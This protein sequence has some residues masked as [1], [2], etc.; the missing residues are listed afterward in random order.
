MSRSRCARCGQIGHWARDCKNEPSERGKRR[1]ASFGGFQAP[2]PLADAEPRVACCAEQASPSYDGSY[3]F[4]VLTVSSNAESVFVGLEVTTGFGLVDAGAQRGVCGQEHV[5]KLVK[6]L[7]ESVGFK[8]IQM[9]TLETLRSIL[10][11]IMSLCCYRSNSSGASEW[12]STCP[13]D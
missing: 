4:T 6:T 11:S 3:S 13:G 9:P 5:D 2:S 1:Q 12:F 7:T 8:P 10:L